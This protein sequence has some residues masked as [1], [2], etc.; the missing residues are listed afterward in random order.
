MTLVKILN[1]RV[2]VYK[3]LEWKQTFSVIYLRHCIL[4]SMPVVRVNP[5]SHCQP[6]T[7]YSGGIR[8]YA[9]CKAKIR[10]Y[11]VCRL[12][13]C[14]TQGRR[15]VGGGEGEG[16]SPSVFIHSDL[17]QKPTIIPPSAFQQ[18]KQPT[19]KDDSISQTSINLTT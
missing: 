2:M 12:K 11:T 15:A 19:N 7:K 16:E 3:V 9:V 6:L 13:V 18:H 17:P 8:L 4:V 14:S 10:L 5:S 1:I